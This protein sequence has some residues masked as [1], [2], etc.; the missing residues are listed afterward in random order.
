MFLVSFVS[1]M[2]LG[3]MFGFRL[4]GLDIMY[5]GN[6]SYFDANL[7][8]VKWHVILGHI[9]KDRMSRL[10]KK[11]LLDWLTKVK[12]PRCESC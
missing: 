7:E 8:S 1:L 10:A 9:R 6:V 5:G 12:L 4:E 3:F 11:G 2:K